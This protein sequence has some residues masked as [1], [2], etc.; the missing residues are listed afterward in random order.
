[1]SLPQMCTVP[2]IEPAML[3]II[4]CLFAESPPV[5]ACLS[6]L[7]R[8][9]AGGLEPDGSLIACRNSSAVE[10]KQTHRL[11]L[12]INIGHV[13]NRIVHYALV[14]QSSRCMRLT[15]AH[16]LTAAPLRRGRLHP[17]PACS[18]RRK[19]ARQNLAAAE[20][21]QLGDQPQPGDLQ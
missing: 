21:P 20:A 18:S 13:Q 8:R 9:L 11:S 12:T 19:R 4:C 10:I 16:P 3:R 7:W 17:L 6:V 15:N 1:M 14:P 5:P 2:L